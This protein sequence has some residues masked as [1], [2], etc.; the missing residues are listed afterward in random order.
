MGQYQVNMNILAPKIGT[1]KVPPH[2]EMEIISL[3]KTA[4]V[5]SWGK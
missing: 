5:V 4:Y 2:N 3:N 1:L